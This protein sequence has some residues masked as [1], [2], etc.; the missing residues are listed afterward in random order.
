[1]ITWAPYSDASVRAW[2]VQLQNQQP[3]T[4]QGQLAAWGNV[5]WV[6][7]AAPNLTYQS[8]QDIVVRGQFVN[9]ATLTNSNDTSYRA[10]SDNWPVFAFSADLG[11][12]SRQAV[13]MPL[14]VGQVRTPAVSYL[15]NSLQP[16]WTT[17][18]PSWHHMAGFFHSGLTAASKRV[19][20]LDAKIKA[21][22]QGTGGTAYTGLCAI[23][24]RQAYGGTELVAGPDGKPWALLKEISSDG[25]VS[26]VDVLYPASP[27]WIYADP[28]YLGLL[29]EP[30]L[31]YAE[32]G[33]WPKTFAEHDLGSAY[34]VA[35][36]HNNGAEED[37][38]AEESGN[39]L[40]MAAACPTSASRTRPMTSPGPSRTASTWPPR[41]S[42]RWPTWRKSPRQRAPPTTATR[43]GC[44]APA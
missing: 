2:T 27:A 17:Y 5:A 9:H 35:S 4:E 24:L 28:A 10:I 13:T 6:T 8:G 16:L 42:S 23:S 41:R 19:D 21:D 25:N 12:V 44:W 29:L 18:F 33:G 22:A 11:Q 38:P 37:M 20:S 32:T 1:M 36:G 34:P 43:T 3:L 40:I 14:S 30:L 15:G 39:M 26:T 7:P 31:A